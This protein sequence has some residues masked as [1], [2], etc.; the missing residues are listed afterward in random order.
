MLYGE[1]SHQ[2]DAK[3]RIRIPFR[4]KKDLGSAYMLCKMADGVIG[5]YEASIA[6]KKF[7]FLSEV[8]PFNKQ[9]KKAI[10]N[11]MSGFFYAEDDGHG[12]IMLPD[13]LVK[14]AKIEKDVVSVGMG[15]HIELM[16]AATFNEAANDDNSEEYLEILDQLFEKHRSE[17]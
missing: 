2:V 16:S 15:D 5:I 8:S 12:R 4:F 6:E 13:S 11:F 9:A 1:F 10:L 17:Q 3:N 14:Y 7:A